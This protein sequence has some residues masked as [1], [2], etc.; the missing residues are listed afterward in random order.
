MNYIFINQCSYQCLRV[1]NYIL[2]CFKLFITLRK[3]PLWTFQ[4]KSLGTKWIRMCFNKS[5]LWRQFQLLYHFYEQWN[6]RQFKIKRYL[7]IRNSQLNIP[8]ILEY[9][10]KSLIK[11]F[12]E[13]LLSW[14]N[15]IRE[16]VFYPAKRRRAC[17][18]INRLW[19]AWFWDKYR[20]SN[21]Y[22]AVIRIITIM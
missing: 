20:F 12:Q 10:W 7:E 17:H 11:L 13:H 14:R 21:N 22:F 5:T 1:I 2:T 18:V 8:L 19:F 4:L 9:L 3:K 6:T 16:T 15:K